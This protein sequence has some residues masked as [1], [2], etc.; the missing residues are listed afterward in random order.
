M[1]SNDGVDGDVTPAAEATIA[2]GAPEGSCQAVF[3]AA[4]A[5]IERW[6]AP[7]G[8]LA[9]AL[10]GFVAREPQRRMAESVLASCL[11]ARSHRLIE[12]PTGVG[13]TFGYLIPVL[14]SR[15]RALIATGTRQLQDQLFDDDLPRL[16]EA[17]RGEL[18]RPVKIARLKGRANYLCHE[19][20]ER[21]LQQHAVA[22][23]ARGERVLLERLAAFAA[24]DL[25]GD[26]SRSDLLRRAPPGFAERVTSTV[27]NCLGHE[28]PHLDDDCFVARAR[29][30][31]LAAD[32]VVV[33][34]HLLLADLALKEQGFA[35]LL[36]DVDVIVVD[37]AHRLPDLA[38]QYFGEH[39]STRRLRVWGLDVRRQL[40]GLASP[41]VERASEALDR[42]LDDL[43]AR[44]PVE[45]TREAR[46]RLV[47]PDPAAR[48]EDARHAA[49]LQALV[50]LDETMADAE[51]VLRKA[52]ETQPEWRPLLDR[53]VEQRA[54]FE[55]FQADDDAREVSW[56][57]R[58]APQPGA[59]LVLHR[60][61]I[62]AAG[63]LA[64]A[65]ARFAAS[66]ILVSATLAVGEDFALARTRFGL[67][68][69]TPA[70]VLP[71]VFD[72]ARQAGLLLAPASIPEPAAPGFTREWLRWLWPVLRDL[73]GGAF[74]LFTSHRA[75]REAAELLTAHAPAD[76]EV[77]VQTEGGSRAALVERFR[78]HG[79]AWLLGAGSFWE[80]VNVPGAALSLV[81]IDKLPFASPDDPV[82]AARAEQL[83]GQGGMFRTW[84]LPNA[85]L[86]L[87]Q[88]VGRLI[89]AQNDRGVVVLCDP[90][91]HSRGYG[92]QVLKALPPMR[93]LASPAAALAFLAGADGAADGG[94]GTID[95]ADPSPGPARAPS[96]GR[97]R[98]EALPR[99]P[100]SVRSPPRLRSEVAGR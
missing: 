70:E 26:L 76:R 67:P 68:K 42:A 35:E 38:G 33:N 19:R 55:R 56:F 13:K 48:P 7:D 9:R 41:E 84:T 29:R 49:V 71:S 63:P 72:H 14:A 73:P 10:P 47:A 15:R 30:Q 93:R 66:W 32:V 3:R 81:V 37:E 95:E 36:P 64:Q 25:D 8:P 27:D 6:L 98:V 74:L 18:G 45:P 51:A 12:A 28:C 54:A 97:S 86:T 75:L 57:E 5:R 90:R 60:T 77:L 20:L 39:F 2:G 24:T 53:L 100:A 83:R 23:S 21:A 46:S 4:Q 31:A 40:R 92:R 94:L 88:G 50:R 16:L 44:W 69:T 59:N 85:I 58:T 91:V 52:L 1:A 61:P 17:L 99:A 22:P 79:R 80:G 78:A 96:L 34:H 43:L 11:T 82:L 62:D 89:R 87:K 65:R